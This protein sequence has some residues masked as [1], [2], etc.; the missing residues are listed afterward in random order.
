MKLNETSYEWAIKHMFKESDNDL[1]PRP[2]ELT[3]I[4]ELLP[5]TISRLKDVE[6]GSY[7]WQAARRFLIPKDNLSFRNA[8][9]IDIIDSIVLGALIYQYGHLIENKRR[10]IHEK[11]VFSYRFLP[12]SDGT[13]YSNKNAWEKFWESNKLEAINFSHIVI[14][15]ISDFYNQIYLHTIENQLAECGFPN[16]IIKSLK[17]FLISIT[18]R[19]SKGIPI[20]PHCSHLLAEMSLIPFDDN[21]FLRGIVFKRYVDDIVVFCS[22]EKEGRIALNQIAEILDKEQRLVLQKQKTKILSRE[23]FITLCK[24][25]L[26][27]ETINSTEEE[28]LEVI[29]SYSSGDAYT[30]I[31]LSEIHDEDLEKLSK[32]SIIQ[33]LNS[34]LNISAPNYEKIRWIYRRLSQ[35]GLPHAIDFSIENFDKLIPALNDVCLYINSCAENYSSDWKA[36]GGYIIELLDD[37]IIASNEFY[38]IALYNLFVFNPNLNHI[39]SLLGHFPSAIDNVRRKILF[40]SMNYNSSGWLRGLKEN[41]NRFDTWTKR[42]YLIAASKLPKEEREFFY[43]GIKAQFSSS[44]IIEELIIKWSAAK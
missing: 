2:F 34:Y 8:T 21:L 5:A 44:D 11:S 29:K 23:E 27:E 30:K 39:S 31:K 9:Q 28:I 24:T 20:G 37:D 35:I 10:P 43:K 40:A 17:E 18:Q 26:L 25:N 1:F 3:I 36:V 16:Q 38:K 4:K 15:D 13:L 32:E 33:L 6:I 12:T 7:K 19:S 42:A 41:Y 14:C 22:S